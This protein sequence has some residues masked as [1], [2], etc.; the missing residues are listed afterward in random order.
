MQPCRTPFLTLNQSI[1]L[2]SVLTVDCSSLYNASISDT[3]LFVHPISLITYHSCWCSTLS[4][5]FVYSIKHVKSGSLNSWHFW[6]IKL[7]I[8]SR[9]Y[10]PCLKPD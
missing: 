3:I 9:V 8:W 1:V 5:A 10:L 2:P 6:M 7:N 4:K